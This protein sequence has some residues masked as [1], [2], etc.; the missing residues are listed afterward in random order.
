MERE[1]KD[2]GSSIS[3]V[4]NSY[5]AGTF[6][7]KFTYSK[8]HHLGT[9][10]IGICYQS[11]ITSRIS[12]AGQKISCPLTVSTLSRT[13]HAGKVAPDNT[14]TVSPNC[15]CH[16]QKQWAA[17]CVQTFVQDR[18]FVSLSNRTLLTWICL[19]RGWYALHRSHRT[20]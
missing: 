6:I 1:I 4:Q 19:T 20:L 9:V 11:N 8:L 10:K 18:F 3:I 15:E 14:R 12:T 2:N 7:S 13:A 17:R 16:E 5:P